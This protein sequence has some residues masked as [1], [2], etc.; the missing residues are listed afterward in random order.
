MRVTLEIILRPPFTPVARSLFKP[1]H[2][3]GQ[4]PYPAKPS[5]CPRRHPD[6]RSPPRPQDLDAAPPMVDFDARRDLERRLSESCPHRRRLLRFTTGFLLRHPQ[7]LIASTRARN[8]IVGGRSNEKRMRV[9]E[10]H[11]ANRVLCTPPHR[12]RFTAAARQDYQLVRRALRTRPPTSSDRQY[13]ECC[14][15]PAGRA[16]RASIA[17]REPLRL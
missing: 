14:G 12:R 1:H 16:A 10:I 8:G 15:S 7:G 13:R 3:L 6:P 4:A 17:V 9:L 5:I 11:S 2:P